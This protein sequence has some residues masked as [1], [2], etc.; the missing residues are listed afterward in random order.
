[1][2]NKTEI[3]LGNW[4]IENKNGNDCYAQIEGIKLVDAENT[5][6]II[7]TQYQTTPIEY[8]SPI[9]L[10]EEILL[11]C[12]FENIYKS[13]YR[14]KFDHNK[15]LY[16]GYD[17]SLCED[18]SMEGFRYYGKYISHIKYLHQLQNLYWCLCGEELEINL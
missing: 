6:C 18:K 16:I 17:F 9:P 7:E 14:N 2:I 5:N 13:E 3:R 15:L 12:G 1:M 11:K 8:I 4:V 10:T